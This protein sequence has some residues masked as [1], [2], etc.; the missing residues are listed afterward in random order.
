[1]ITCHDCPFYGFISSIGC[2]G[3]ID[4]KDIRY[5]YDNRLF[6]KDEI[7]LEGYCSTIIYKINNG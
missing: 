2:S 1:M 3:V 4:E 5:S 7:K 6:L